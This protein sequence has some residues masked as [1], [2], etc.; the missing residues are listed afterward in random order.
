M[1]N[2]SIFTPTYN[3]CKTLKRLYE[4]IIQQNYLNCEWI[5]VDDGSIDDTKKLIND[6]IKEN[7]III[8]Y[9]YQKNSGKH[10][11]I[12]KGVE[13]ASGEVF[14]I[15]DSDDYLSENALN[16]INH[17]FKG[18]NDKSFAGIGGLKVFS[19]GSI[20][21][22][23]FNN[24]KDYLDATS[25]D[26]R[27]YD[28]LGDKAECFYTDVIRKYPFPQFENEKFFSEAYIWNKIAADGYKIRWINKPLITCQY[29]EDGI[30]RNYMDIV[31]KSPMGHLLYLEDLIK[32]EKNFFRKVAHYT[33]Y[34]H[35]A[36]KI[37]SDDEIRN[38]LKIGMFKLN[39][40]RIISKIRWRG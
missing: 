30:T 37:Y 15:V 29:L 10:I 8:K 6:F 11:A 25:L 20:I 24:K 12:N 23:T 35:C 1:I 9:F 3:R 18:I 27:K 5:V 34:Y 40:I 14:L 22:K 4:S 17:N 33:S 38:K 2:I 7:K 36:E 13:V 31:K 16:I 32:F 39:F 19:D 26:R 28:I 21:G